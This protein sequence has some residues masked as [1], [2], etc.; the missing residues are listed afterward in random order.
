MARM[1][2]GGQSGQGMPR[3]YWKRRADFVNSQKKIAAS[4]RGRG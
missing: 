3:P 4:F 1:E 2:S